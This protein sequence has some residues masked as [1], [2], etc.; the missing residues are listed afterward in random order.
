M[1]LIKILTSK[2]IDSKNYKNS[3]KSLNLLKKQNKLKTIS[4]IK[5]LDSSKVKQNPINY[6]LNLTITQTNTIINL[7]DSTGKLL[8]SLS[9]GSLNLKKR[10]KKIQPLA[11]VTLLK[12]LILT[13]NFTPEKSI[14]LHFK[15]VKSYY[16][17]LIID[18]LKKVI[19]IKSIKSLNLQPHNGCR[20]KKL[21][22]FKR[23]TKKT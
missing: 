9:G 11:L 21:K 18:L 20:P 4:K 14:A 15:N 17:S 19:F 16:E 22:K 7:S 3:L 23:R 10:Q 2:N 13:A 5:N 12:S 1:I 6:I 8:I